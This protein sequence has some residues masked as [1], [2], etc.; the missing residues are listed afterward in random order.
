MKTVPDMTSYIK[1]LIKANGMRSAVN[2]AFRYTVIDTPLERLPSEKIP[3][4]IIYHWFEI[5]SQLFPR[6]SDKNPLD[7][8]WLNPAKIE[9]LHPPGYPRPPDRY[10]YVIGGDWD[11]KRISFDNH[12]IHESLVDRYKNNKKWERT[13]LYQRCISSKQDEVAPRELSTPKELDKYLHKIDSLYDSIEKDGY[14]TQ[15]QLISENPYQ[16]QQQNNDACHPILNEICVNIGRNGELIKRGS[17]HHRLSIAKILNIDKVPVIVKTRHKKWQ[18]LRNMIMNTGST[19][20]PN[21]ELKKHSNHPDLKDIISS[22]ND[23]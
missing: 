4:S 13:E 8:V 23:D 17:G 3:I 20:E 10:G 6:V 1:N 11:K 7:L 16:T 5:R 18:H 22:T 2:R 14:K 21:V 9:Y 15:Q 12:F 19:D